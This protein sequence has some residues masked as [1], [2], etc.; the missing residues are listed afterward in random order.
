MDVKS[1]TTDR[2]IEIVCSFAGDSCP[3]N[4]STE[5]IYVNISETIIFTSFPI[6]IWNTFGV[7]QLL[8]PLANKTLSF[9]MCEIQ[10]ELG[11]QDLFHGG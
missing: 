7:I 10:I 3:Y 6:N 11:G 5:S 2:M 9:V 4:T 8:K 1:K